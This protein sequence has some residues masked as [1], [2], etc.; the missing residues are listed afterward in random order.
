MQEPRIVTAAR[1]IFGLFYFANGIGMVL[2]TLFG[3][4]TPPSQPTAEA[5]AFT[6]ALTSSHFMDPLVSLV[7]L[8]G[9][10]ALLLRRSAPLGVIVLTPVVVAIF[11]FHATLSGQWIWG[12]VNLTWLLALAWQF[13][14]AFYPLWTYPARS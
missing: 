9:G 3:I 4:G 5:G 10:G 7:Y 12:S 11:F 8:V 14:S 6:V 1:W 2:H 13:R